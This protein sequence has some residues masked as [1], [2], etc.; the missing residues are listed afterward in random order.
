[1][2]SPRIENYLNDQIYQN[3]QILL[4]KHLNKTQIHTLKWQLSR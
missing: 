2:L 1:M 3:Y 4:N